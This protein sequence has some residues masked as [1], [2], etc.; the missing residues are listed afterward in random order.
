MKPNELPAVVD[1]FAPAHAESDARRRFSGVAR[2][3]GAAGSARLSAAHVVVVG[4]GG[5]GSWTAEALARSGVGRITLVDL[6]HIAESNTNRQ[7]HALTENFGRAKVE[8][9]AQ[10]CRAIHPAMRIDCIE[11]FVTPENVAALLPA[12]DAVIDCID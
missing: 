8:A 1:A 6:D 10:R 7:I 2:L 5:V 3:Y 9:M 11:E 4:I 12:C